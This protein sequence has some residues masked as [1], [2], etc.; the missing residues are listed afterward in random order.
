MT[1]TQY[2]A[3]MV[4]QA[5]EKIIRVGQMVGVTPDEIVA[6]LDS[7]RTIRELLMFLA[8]KSTAVRRRA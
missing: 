3:E 5:A 4:N 7:G 1:D 6:F 8:S 2:E